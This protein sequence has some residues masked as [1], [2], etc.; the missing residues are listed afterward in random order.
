VSVFANRG[1]ISVKDLSCGSIRAV[2]P[3]MATVLERRATHGRATAPHTGGASRV[4][5]NPRP[6]WRGDRPRCGCGR[7]AGTQCRAHVLRRDDRR[8]QAVD[9]VRR[10]LSHPGSNHP[11]RMVVDFGWHLG[12]S[13]AS[14][15][16]HR[17]RA[18]S[19]EHLRIRYSLRRSTFRSR[20][21]TARRQT[22]MGANTFDR[23]VT[24]TAA[25][26]YH[27]QCARAMRPKRGPA[28]QLPKS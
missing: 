11:S 6:G 23:T 5:N 2:R 19:A 25:L 18:D 9:R 13:A 10:H 15:C 24:D 28:E 7:H 27:C 17:R 26:I 1:R 3:G 12:W 21:P 22:S 20:D 14:A 16:T 8:R 4:G